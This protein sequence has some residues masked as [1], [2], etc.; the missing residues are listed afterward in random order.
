MAG[1]L[2]AARR[3]LSQLGFL[4]VDTGRRQGNRHLEKKGWILPPAAASWREWRRKVLESAGSRLSDRSC[5]GRSDGGWHF[6]IAGRDPEPSR[7]L[8]HLRRLLRRHDLGECGGQAP[9]GPGAPILL[10]RA[11]RRC[12]YSSWC[13]PTPT[14]VPSDQFPAQIPFSNFARGTEALAG[15]G[16]W[17]RTVV[18]GTSVEAS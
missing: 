6:L 2:G 9:G 5:S 14:H 10:R 12:P 8:L 4:G 3:V 7:G 15:A 17:P 16:G 1:G 11:Q 18:R 13:P